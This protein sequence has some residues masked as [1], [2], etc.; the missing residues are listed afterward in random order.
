MSSQPGARDP[1]GAI[2]RV[3]RLRVFAETLFIDDG[4][5][6]GD[7]LVGALVAAASEGAI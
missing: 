2:C 1:V 5:R 4:S 3:S 7:E 6:E